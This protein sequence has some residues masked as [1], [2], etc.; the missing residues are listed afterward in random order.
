MLYY[1]GNADLPGKMAHSIQEM[2]MCEA[3]AEIGQEVV[4]LHGHELGTRGKVNWENVADHYGLE[5]RF[6]IKTFRNFQNKTG[7]FTEPGTL[8][9]A[10]P[11]STYV[12]LKVLTGRVSREDIIYGRNYYSLYFL[13]EL[14]KVVPDKNRPVVVYEHHNPSKR[15]FRGRF[16]NQLDGLV[17]LTEK[18]AHYV[19]ETHGINRDR[20]FVAPDAVNLSIYESLSRS[21]ARRELGLPTNETIVMYTGH[22]YEGKGVE[23]LIYAANKLDTL[24]YIV[25]GHREDIER[26]EQEMDIPKNVIFT[27]FIEPS[28]IS[29]YQ[30][31]ADV[32]VAPYDAR[33]RPHVS[34]L[35]LFEYMAAGRPIVASDRKVLNEVL[36]DG[37]NALQFS[38]GDA[39]E[40]RKAINKLL[41]DTH[42][43]NKLICNAQETVSKHT[44]DL[45]AERIVSFIR[46]FD[47]S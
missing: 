45:R 43:Y 11:I 25:G 26:L 10:G 8:S 21:T 37:K 39:Y 47:K 22:C 42:L 15:R 33:S 6:T 20:I 28:K 38:C 36:E 5:R 29:V 30:V 16:L 35:K 46:S 32:L 7:R 34:P 31:A 18:L 12:F 40:L 19:V 44:W 3:F 2:R 23:T 9:M 1:L 4:Y 13:T 17:C 27:G 14:L 24:V 41:T